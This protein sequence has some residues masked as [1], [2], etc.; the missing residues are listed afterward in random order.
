MKDLPR[1]TFWREIIDDR[2]FA[3]FGR[4]AWRDFDAAAHFMIVEVA[5]WKTWENREKFQV[6]ITEKIEEHERD[7][8]A[9][10]GSRQWVNHLTNLDVPKRAKLR[11]PT[12]NAW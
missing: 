4:R 2:A 8:Y 7:L 12:E 1:I 9:Y 5:E 6:A 11:P 3:L 10:Y